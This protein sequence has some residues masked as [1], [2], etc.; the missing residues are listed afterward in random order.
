[1]KDHTIYQK[2]W[3]DCRT[4]RVPREGPREAPWGLLVPQSANT[5]LLWLLAITATP[6][7]ISSSDIAPFSVN[8]RRAEM[9]QS[10]QSK[11]QQK[12]V[13][14]PAA[15]TSC[16][17]TFHDF[18]NIKVKHIKSQN[19]PK[20]FIQ[21]LQN[22]QLLFVFICLRVEKYPHYLKLYL[23]SSIN[24]EPELYIIYNTLLI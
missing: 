15:V 3:Y 5:M 1:M 17:E 16:S 9:H 4:E 23:Y 19:R 20:D 6:Y 13:S 24:S 11:C 21:S 14:V 7:V 8:D 10:S 22:L 2:K 18:I 12:R